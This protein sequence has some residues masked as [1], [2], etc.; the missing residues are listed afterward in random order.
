MKTPHGITVERFR[1]FAILS[2]NLFI[3]EENVQGGSAT[4]L[5]HE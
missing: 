3:C 1:K 2:R 5:T 4:T